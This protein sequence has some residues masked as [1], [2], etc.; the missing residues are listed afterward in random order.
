MTNRRTFLA[1][2]AAFGL[3]PTLTWAEVGSTAYISAARTKN[4]SY[5]LFGLTKEGGVSFEV[6]LPD[7]GHAAAA[8]PKRAE[9]VGF[10]R[11]PGR[12]AL[13]IDCAEGLIRQVLEPPAGRHFYGH[14][15]YTA[16]GKFLFTS[17]NDFENAQGMIGVWRVDRQYQ[18]VGEFPSN[19]VGPHDVKLMPDGKHLVVANGG[20]ETHPDSGR[21]KLNIPMMEPNLSYLTLKGD[22][23]DQLELPRKM[24]KNSIRHLGVGSDG[25][26]A[27]AMQWQGDVHSSPA[28]LGLHKP[29]QQVRLLEVPGHLHQRL[30]GYI[31][32]IAYSAET[33][34]VAA[35]SPRGN[36]M[37]LLDAQSGQLIEAVEE[38][39]VCG[40]AFRG[41]DLIRSAGTGET[42]VS[43]G[44]TVLHRQS[45]SHQWDNH[46]VPLA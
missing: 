27:F 5:A 7:R 1:G 18:R 43:Q 4:G 25:Q 33:G 36:L 41:T 42:C 32:S 26:V 14:G 45:F 12:F 6:P 16:N 8:H 40:V 35:T 44:S 17:E 21:Q 34:Q 38:A 23:V 3:C 10:A 29:G 30:K 46:L 2:M 15:T 19:G 39:D 11:R 24:H 31:G 20:I 37:L 28:L 22:V 9:V 13:V